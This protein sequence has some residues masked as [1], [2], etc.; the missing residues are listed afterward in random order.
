MATSKNSEE[1]KLR[2]QVNEAIEKGFEET[3]ADG[4]GMVVIKDGAIVVNWKVDEKC[5][6]FDCTVGTAQLLAFIMEYAEL[7][8]PL[9]EGTFEPDAGFISLFGE[10]FKIARGMI[11]DHRL[12]LGEKM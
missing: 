7:E 1:D 3:N 5:T 4:V 2:D 10:C 8:Q 6:L 11:K 9:L 12:F